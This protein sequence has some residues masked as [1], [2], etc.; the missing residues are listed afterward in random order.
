MPKL[1]RAL[2]SRLAYY[3]MANQGGVLAPRG[4]HCIGFYG[5]GGNGLIVLPQR[6]SLD[7]FL[8]G[9]LKTT[10]PLVSWGYILGQTSG[11]LRVLDEGARFFGADPALRQKREEAAELYNF[12]DADDPLIIVDPNPPPPYPEDSLMRHGDSVVTY[13][14]A[15][16]TDGIGMGGLTQPGPDPLHGAVA[17]LRGDLDLEDIQVRLPP[18]LADLVPVLLDQVVAYSRR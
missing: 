12:M 7:Q 10:G 2:A 15:P 9:D 16:M 8:S 5:T 6:F 13:R 11:R 3:G 1:P 18:A 4:W 17:L 14:V